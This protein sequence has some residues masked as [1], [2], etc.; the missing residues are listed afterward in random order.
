MIL[1]PRPHWLHLLFVRRGS[2]LQRI[3]SQQLFIFSI[4]VLVVVFHGQLFHWKVTLTSGPFS[5]M[6]VALAIFLGFRINA[7]YDRY[8]EARKLWGVIGTSVGVFLGAVSVARLGLLRTLIIGSLAG[9]ISNL[10]FIWL[11]GQGTDF[12]QFAVINSVS[13][14]MIGAKKG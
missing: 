3:V 5:L 9:P 11:A 7:S 12:V 14:T 8:W 4:S 10:G 1:R 6:G 13:P 2:L